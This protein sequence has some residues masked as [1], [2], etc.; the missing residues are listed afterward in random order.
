MRK[1]FIGILCAL[2]LVLSGCTAG[3]KKE[4]ASSKS[5]PKI[6]P[7]EQTATIP[8]GTA[9][10]IRLAQALSSGKNKAGDSFEASLEKALE[11]NG[12]VIAPRGS[13]VL[14]KVSRAISS[15]KVKG[16]A[17]MSLTLSEIKVGDTRL[18]LL[19]NTLSFQAQAT[20][21]KDAGIIGGGAGLGAAIGAIAGGGKGAAIG[22]L[23]GAGGG[24]A[25]VMSTKGK[26]LEFAPEQKFVFKLQEEVKTM[27]K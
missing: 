8:A 9:I 4:E 1:N 21:K 3:D 12:K 10:E 24:T 25:V 13:A 22:A 7:V 5:A 15:G 27:I 23:A 2:A 19:T 26:E 20:K 14:G 16:R 18:A 11:V 6:A 17:E